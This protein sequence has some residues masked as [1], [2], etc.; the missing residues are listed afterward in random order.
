MEPWYAIQEVNTITSP[1]LLIYKARVEENINAMIRLVESPLRLMPHVKTHKLQEIVQMQ[2]DK[3]ITKFKCATV[4]EAEMLAGAGA[5]EVLLAY[6]LVGPNIQRLLQLVQTF[7]NTKFASV[8]DDLHAAKDLGKTFHAADLNAYVYVDID[9]GMH[10]TGIAVDKAFD[11]YR[12]LQSIDGLVIDGIHVYDG[13]IREQDIQ[14]REIHC[15]QDFAPVMQLVES[16]LEAGISAPKII[17][18]GSPTF[19]IHAKHPERIC[20]PG[21]SLLWDEGYRKGLPEQPFLPA[22]VLLTRVISIPEAGKV[23]TDLGHKAVAAENTIDKRVKFLNLDR[24]EVLSQSEEHM[25]IATQNS[26]KVGDVLYA[27]PYHVCPT[28]ALYQEAFVIENGKFAAAWQI[29]ARQR[30]ITI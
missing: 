2:I 21:T 5:E 19:T 6:Q 1:S 4:A 20:S 26:L 28:V 3:G 17:A 11:L 23:T 30:K 25:V 10:R 15:D 9:N 24:Y 27:I 7:D 22:A 16:I 12:S 13:H 29:S 8:V 18:G 14:Q